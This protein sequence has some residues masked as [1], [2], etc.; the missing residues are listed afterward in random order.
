MR[1]TAFIIMAMLASLGL[2]SACSSDDNADNQLTNRL[3]SISE[4]NYTGVMCYD[5]HGVWCISFYY[6]GT[7]DSVD[8]FYPLNL[9]EEFKLKGL[10][11]LFSGKV[12]E[13][14]AED[15]KSQQIEPLGGHR[16]YFVYITSISKC[17]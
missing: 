6:P 2:L 3:Q 16:Y 5:Q 12:V 10:N 17:E 14:T 9:P 8:T 15:I 4:K 1:K 13:M 7:Y 11:V